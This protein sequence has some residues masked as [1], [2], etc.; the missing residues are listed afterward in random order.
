MIM[1]GPEGPRSGKIMKADKRT[2]K[3]HRRQHNDSDD[4]ASASFT[5]SVQY[6]TLIDE[7]KSIHF[8]TNHAL[9]APGTAQ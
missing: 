7:D 5:D 9:R 6:W 8:G 4:V 2:L 3:T 1:S